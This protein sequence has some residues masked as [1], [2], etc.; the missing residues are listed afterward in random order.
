MISK[1]NQIYDNFYSDGW[2][3]GWEEKDKKFNFFYLFKI[4]KYCDQLLDESSVLDVGCGTGD[5]VKYL[6]DDTE[7]LGIDIYRPGLKIAKSKYKDSIFKYGNILT[8]KSVKKFDYVICSGALSVHHV[9]NYEFLKKS[10]SKMWKLC[11]K[12]VTFNLLT[13]EKVK[14]SKKEILFVYNM[15]KVQEICKKIIGEEGQCTS[16]YNPIDEYN[17]QHTI[18][19]VRNGK[20][21]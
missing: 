8:F 20:Y 4:E 14:N 17:D 18:Y 13:D 16:V 6:P 7:Y 12:G 21:D 3:D 1:N 11:E 19:L 5:M 15:K 2:E 10:I 9:D